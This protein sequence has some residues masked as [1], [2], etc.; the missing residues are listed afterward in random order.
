MRQM[1]PFIVAAIVSTGCVLSPTD[2]DTVATRLEP[3]AWHGYAK[4]PN[5][6]MQIRAWNYE[7]ST[8]DLVRS[9]T[10]S[11]ARVDA[12]QAMYAWQSDTALGNRYWQPLGTPCT[13]AGTARLQVR[14]Q[15]DGTWTALPT[16]D[17]FGE[18]CL[19]DEVRAGTDYVLAGSA[20]Y[21]G[22]EV[23]LRSPPTCVQASGGSA[24]DTYLT[25]TD[26]VTAWQMDKY[27]WIDAVASLGTPVAAGRVLRLRA[28][29]FGTRSLSAISVTYEATVTCVS[30]AG[31][32]RN[33]TTSR[34]RSRPVALVGPDLAPGTVGVD[35]DVEPATL[36]SAC[37]AGTTARSA[38]L[39]VQAHPTP[40]GPVAGWAG[41]PPTGKFTMP[42]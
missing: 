10:G 42:L 36:R 11:N 18:E 7:R 38:F 20:C 40:R 27:S 25:V 9:F 2:G 30:S 5:A 33:V 8:W 26:D 13:T 32:T 3:L 1:S 15:V 28:D 35:L 6:S 12:S 39:F 41:Y 14:E 29:G 23:V 37:P 21:T 24:L 34:T 31:A 4:D 17:V 19:Y 16:F 22:D